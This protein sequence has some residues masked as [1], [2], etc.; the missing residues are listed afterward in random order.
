LD[1]DG[2]ILNFGTNQDAEF[3]ALRTPEKIDMTK[4]LRGP[5]PDPKTGHRPRNMLKFA[6][7]IGATILPLVAMAPAANAAGASAPSP[8][9][10]YPDYRAEW[11]AGQ[12]TPNFHRYSVDENANVHLNGWSSSN[13]PDDC[14]RGCASGDW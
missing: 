14:N 10:R 8:A 5:Y 11:G 4:I 3:S 13:G 7:I 12:A 6:A 2:Q 1:R 9:T